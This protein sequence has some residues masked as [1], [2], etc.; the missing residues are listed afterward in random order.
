MFNFKSIVNAVIN[1]NSTAVKVI[2]YSA[3]AVIGIGANAINAGTKKAK[4]E[5]T[6]ADKNTVTEVIHDE[7]IIEEVYE[8]EAE[9]EA[10][11]RAALDTF[12]MAC[13]E[14]IAAKKDGLADA[15][16]AM[17][18]LAKWQLRQIHYNLGKK[19][20]CIVV[21]DA[22]EALIAFRDFGPTGIEWM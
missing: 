1:S 16:M 11:M 9:F 19:K 2:G 13:E 15:A 14:A 3:L 6:V 7:D 12:A 5:E 18:D 8:E 22:A 20:K 4:T 17:E 21:H 10:G